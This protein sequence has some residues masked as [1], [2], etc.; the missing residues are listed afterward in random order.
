MKTIKRITIILLFCFITIHCS[1]LTPF[2]DEKMTF[3]ARVLD[4]LN[5]NK[6]EKAINLL[7]HRLTQDIDID[8]KTLT[9]LFLG[10][11]YSKS[12]QPEKALEEY[13]KIINLAPMHAIAYFKKADILKSSTNKNNIYQAIADYKKSY[14]LGF[15]SP[16]IFSGLGTCYALLL[17]QETQ[18]KAK[19][20]EY[21]NMSK[22]N[23]QEALKLTPDDIDSLEH[24]ADIEY[25]TGNYLNAI[26]SYKKIFNISPNN[27][28]LLAHMGLT[29][30]AINQPHKAIKLLTQAQEKIRLQN[31]SADTQTKNTLY[32]LMLDVHLYLA[33]AYIAADMP[34]N[35][36]NELGLLAGKS[37]DAFNEPFAISTT[38][39][40]QQANT[41]I[42]NLNP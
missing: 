12:F 39:Y 27:V 34:D 22:Y 28:T 9:H 42:D 16:L 7:N 35:A 23:Y 41:L 40:K 20:N 25:T 14:S 26:E 21:Y 10:D 24:L 13:K 6:T 18:N 5:D 30:I 11:I 33:Q 37:D 15:S 4:T 17:N 1:S 32:R 19:K 36:K 8:E 2:A 38:F 3:Q 31:K 29:Y